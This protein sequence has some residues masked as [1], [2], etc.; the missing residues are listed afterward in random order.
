MTGIRVVKIRNGG[1]WI[2]HGVPRPDTNYLAGPPKFK[3][4]RE[5]MN[6]ATTF[7]IDVTA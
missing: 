7:S 2:V 6:Y 3:T 4:W 5:A 1:G